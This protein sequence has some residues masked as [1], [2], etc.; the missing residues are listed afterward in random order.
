MCLTVLATSRVRVGFPRGAIYLSIYLPGLVALSI[1]LPG[2]VALPFYLSIYLS[3]CLYVYMYVYIY[4]YICMRDAEGSG[5]LPGAAAGS[6][7]FI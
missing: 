5:R 4:I 7:D 2:L 1:Y 6:H 3:V